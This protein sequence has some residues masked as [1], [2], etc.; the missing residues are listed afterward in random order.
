MNAIRLTPTLSLIILFTCLLALLAPPPAA[1]QEPTPFSH[2]GWMA[3]PLDPGQPAPAPDTPPDA[4]VRGWWWRDGTNES[5][6]EQHSLTEFTG[7]TEIVYITSGLKVYFYRALSGPNVA[8]VTTP[9]NALIVGTGGDRSLALTALMALRNI[10]PGFLH[11]SPSGIVV[12]D[13]HADAYRGIGIWRSAFNRPALPAYVNAAF[14]VAKAGFDHSGYYTRQAMAMGQSLSW[15]PDALLG[16]GSMRAYAT[17]FID[18]DPAPTSLISAPTTITVENEIIS[19]IPAPGREAGL[20]VWIPRVRILLAGDAGAFLPDVGS[21]YR[22]STPVPERI[23]LLDTMIGLAPAYYIT[24]NG[25]PIVG[26]SA[27][28][29]ALTAQR[30][31]LQSIYDQTLALID[32]QLT[33]SEV[34]AAVALPADL[35]ASPYNR[36][37]ASNIPG[38]VRNIYHERMGW[39]GGE[40]PDLAGTLTPAAKASA[41]AE[42]LGGADNL[43]A[44]ARTAELNAR[45]LAA[46]EKALYLAYAAFHAAPD[47]F[48]ARQVYAQALRKNA[49]MQTNAQNRNYYLSE[50][51]QL[52]TEQIVTDL[53]K[54]GEEDAAIAFAAAD[55]AQHFFG[56]LG[57]GL[58]TVKIVSLPPAEHGMLALAGA[59]VTAGQEIPLAELDGLTFTPA[60]DWNGDTSFA[61]NGK[62]GGVYCTADASVAINILP[63]NDAP[64]VGA[65][66][67]DF[68]VPEDFG[69]STSISTIGPGTWAADSIVIG[70][71]GLP[72]ISSGIWNG[73]NYERRVAHCGDAACSGATV[74][75]VD[76]EGDVGLDGSIV[77]GANGLPVI[78]YADGTNLNAKVATCNDAACTSATLVAVEGT[79]SSPEGIRSP[80]IA[81]GADELPVISYITGDDALKVIHCDDDACSRATVTTVDAGDGSYVPDCA[82]AIGT[83]GLPLISYGGYDYTSEDRN[84]LRIAHCSDAACSAPATITRVDGT[85]GEIQFVSMAIGT[86]GLPI[87][88]YMDRIANDLK[89][90]RCH[91]AACTSATTINLDSA[92]VVGWRPSIAIGA[93]GLPVI[94]YGVGALGQLELDDLKVAHCSD[95][96]CTSATFSTVDPGDVYTHTSIAVGPDGLP[97]IAYLTIDLESENDTLKVAHCSNAFCAPSLP[98]AAIFDDADGDELAY[99]VENDRLDLVSATV[100]GTNLVLDYGE[101]QHGAATIRVTAT[102]PSGLAVSDDFV[103]TVSPVNDAPAVAAPIADAA[104]DEDAPATSLDLSTTFADLDGD[105]LTYAVAANSNPD[106]VSAALDGAS[107]I[108]SFA[109]NGSG[110]ATITISATDPAGLS[111]ADEFVITVNRVNDAP[112]AGAPIADIT[113][114]E[115]AGPTAIELT[116][117]FTDADGDP[118]VYAAAS[119]NPAL[120]GATV[121]G[122]TLTLTFGA[123]QNGAAV[124]TVTATDPSGE[125]AT[126]DF[127]VTVTPVNDAPWANSQ[128]VQ[129]TAGVSRSMTL[130]YGDIDTASGELTVEITTAPAHGT[131][132]G[133]GTDMTY[134]AE[135]GYSGPDSF[136]Y[137]VSDGELASEPAT[138]TIDVAQT[139]IGGRV[140]N[141]ADGDGLLETGEW[142]LADVT[143]QLQDTGGAVLATATTAADGSYAFGSLAAGVYRVRPVLPAGYMQTTPDPAD[144]TLADGQVVPGIDFGLVY[145]ADV[146]VTMTA[147]VNNKTIIYTITVTNDGPADAVDTVLTDTLPAGISFVSVICTQGTCSGGKTVTCSFGTLVSGGS[148]TVTLKVNRTDKDNAIVNSATVAA[149]TFDINPGNNSATATVE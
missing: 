84:V 83:D 73:A 123:N 45:D 143:V 61:W 63:V 2:A 55:F 24:S 146:R 139:V 13:A 69:G 38:V 43:V 132:S 148:A 96:A 99:T 37:L 72:V 52:G 131:L 149:A 121:E 126:S 107:L 116:G 46:A 93:D 137:T 128:Q 104:V 101:N 51:L 80:S 133:V 48:A 65:P 127:A 90:S 76:S 7:G 44:A 70:A 32:Q 81:I 141:D 136:T 8:V 16:A 31:A 34:A 66:F 18:P 40:T 54:S 67:A 142:G 87:V 117:A 140:V 42:A 110:Q 77:I 11:M 47:S 74:T 71:D 50:A 144:I 6:I 134:T 36:E 23:E 1:A 98:L 10:I 62:D 58:E 14:D 100:D 113:V 89:V 4:L 122:A 95:L 103:V 97:V 105:H 30:D 27:I 130:E 119:D 108:L 82:I 12:L 135:A 41:L 145:S 109:A 35:A 20:L 102:D 64:A 25:S 86:D 75:T 91:D 26:A 56:I 21:I 57:S 29:A 92:G 39:F 59:G 68:T 49:F 5:V 15:G 112:A 125:T 115:D 118:L 94:S 3:D 17:T 28:A 114:D 78:A 79:V 147:S 120:A 88:A 138:V 53:A 60:G 33:L 85:P 9:H 124:I 106:L 111:A 19:L 22:A 129:A